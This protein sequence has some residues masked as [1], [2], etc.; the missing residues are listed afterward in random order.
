MTVSGRGLDAQRL[1]SI[2][3]REGSV[4]HPLVARPFELNP[5]GSFSEVATV[6]EGLQLGRLQLLACNMRNTV[7]S[8]SPEQCARLIVEVVR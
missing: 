1:A 7:T 2:G 5:D 4:V 8:D 6:P 3:I